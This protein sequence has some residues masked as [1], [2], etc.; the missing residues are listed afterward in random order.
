MRFLGGLNDLPENWQNPL[1]SPGTPNTNYQDAVNGSN[2]QTHQTYLIISDLAKKGYPELPYA[3]PGVQNPGTIPSEIPS[4]YFPPPPPRPI[5]VVNTAP[6]P[7]L[8]ATTAPVEQP[9]YVPPAVAPPPPVYVPP[10]PPVYVPP[11][12][13]VFVPKTGSGFRPKASL[14]D[15]P[16]DQKSAFPMPIRGMSVTGNM[17]W[18]QGQPVLNRG[19]PIYFN[20]A[21][22]FLRHAMV[23]SNWDDVEIWLAW[24]IAN[25]YPQDKLYAIDFGRYKYSQ[26]PTGPRVYFPFSAADYSS[27]FDR[28]IKY[29][30]A[31]PA[32]R[33]CI[34]KKKEL[35]RR[36]VAS[37]PRNQF[38]LSLSDCPL[39]TGW[40]LGL[41]KAVAVIAIPYAI[42]TAATAIAA[43][44]ATTAAAG[45]AGAAASV[46]ASGSV[47]A[48]GAG[49]GAGAISTAASVAIPVIETVV[50][51]AAAPVL[52]VAGAASIAAGISAG[53]IL[54]TVT[55][56]PLSAPSIPTPQAAPTPQ[57]V[58][59][60]V[61]VQA[62]AAP[63][64]SPVVSGAIIATAAA[65]AI[66]AP[67][68]SAQPIETI[69]VQGQR[70]TEIQL[71]P[72]TAAIVGSSIINA[73]IPDIQLPGAP[74][75]PAFD[76]G[77]GIVDQLKQAAGTAASDFLKSKLE[78]SLSKK[79]G[80]NMG[81]ETTLPFEEY[82]P[83]GTSVSTRP[84][85]EGVQSLSSRLLP[86]ILGLI[87]FAAVFA[88]TQ[89]RARKYRVRKRR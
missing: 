22:E 33:D 89:K 45:T 82:A 34:N 79:L 86:V 4:V 3:G 39:T 29:A 28:F 59:E 58:I 56:P 65:P 60:T 43:A 12:P 18:Y 76:S 74:E 30:T 40:A 83:I 31:V 77:N 68:I 2:Y 80:A 5:S 41:L 72:E 67:S 85:G 84:S 15:I 16:E 51:T 44:G 55:P 57:P 36:A 8:I 23:E 52:T 42:A 37:N 35:Y 70:P 69:T 32:D 73:S 71:D 19:V 10:P 87:A 46:G 27:F 6:P 54:A 88:T 62:S 1:Y 21:N 61:V 38:Q 24:A 50:V 11:P 17:Y 14:S 49:I 66:L 13:P 78:E 47:A 48:T 53:A 20:D 7:I 64:I 75:V 26:G 25:G 81:M 9:I 63:A